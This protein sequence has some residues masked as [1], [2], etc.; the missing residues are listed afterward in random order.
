MPCKPNAP[1]WL[2]LLGACRIHGNVEMGEGV[3]KHV[4]ELDPENA[5]AMEM[6]MENLNCGILNIYDS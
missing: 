6:R 4:L 1:I 5:T 3:A 2:A